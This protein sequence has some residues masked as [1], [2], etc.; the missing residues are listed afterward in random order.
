M[1]RRV[2]LAVAVTG[3]MGGWVPSALASGPPSN[4]GTSRACS[5]IDAS[6]GNSEAA[7]GTEHA[8]SVIGCPNDSNGSQ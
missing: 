6:H 2:L 7:Q 4:S 8:E 3:L 1:R 5:A